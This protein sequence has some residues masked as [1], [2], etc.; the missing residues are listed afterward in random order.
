MEHHTISTSDMIHTIVKGLFQ[1]L[2]TPFVAATGKRHWSNTSQ[3]DQMSC[4]NSTS[5]SNLASRLSFSWV[6]I[7]TRGNHS[8]FTNAYEIPVILTVPNIAKNIMIYCHKLDAQPM[9]DLFSILGTS[10]QNVARPTSL[11]SGTTRNNSK[12]IVRTS[13]RLPSESYNKTQ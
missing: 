5:S 1:Q 6:V 2:S 7:T 9:G 10:S 8:S 13:S 3:R 4:H 12:S 11:N